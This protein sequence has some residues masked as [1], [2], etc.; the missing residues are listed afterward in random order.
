MTKVDISTAGEEVIN[1]LVD[2]GRCESANQAVDIS[3]RL[4]DRQE[5][6]LESLR[7]DIAAGM[8]EV[9]GKHTAPLDMEAI[10]KESEER[11]ARKNPTA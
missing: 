7:Q 5:A 4:L 3:L 9:Y 1:R 8:E 6:L 2:S 11:F 10:I